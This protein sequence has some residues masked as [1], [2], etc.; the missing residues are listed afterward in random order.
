L[1]AS[2]SF[3]QQTGAHILLGVAEVPAGQLQLPTF[4]I[5]ATGPGAAQA[6]QR[7]APLMKLDPAIAAP[8]DSTISAGHVV[9]ALMRQLVDLVPPFSSHSSGTSHRSMSAAAGS[10]PSTGTSGAVSGF[11]TP[12]A[13]AGSTIAIHVSFELDSTDGLRKVTFGL[14]KDVKGTD[15]IWFIHFQ[16]QEKQSASDRDF[17]NVVTLDVLVDEQALHPAAHA[18][19]ENGLTPSQA[20]HALGPAADAAKGTTTGDVDTDTAGETIKGTLKA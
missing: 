12:T 10:G 16:L 1:R 7:L 9:R 3:V 6:W 15:D 14:E 18:A 8:I 19:A 5:P 17:T 2:L 13:G 20:A 11:D 4:P